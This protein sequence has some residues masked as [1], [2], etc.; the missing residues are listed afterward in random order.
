MTMLDMSAPGLTDYEG[1]STPAVVGGWDVDRGS[2]GL[3]PGIVGATP[4]A[5]NPPLHSPD[6][7]LF[8]FG[9]LL[10]VGTGAI[11]VS[12]HWKIGRESG[13]LAV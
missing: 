11:F 8:W 9:L 13:S 1:L 5:N 12:T 10:L 6:N 7:P 2:G 4:P 3:T